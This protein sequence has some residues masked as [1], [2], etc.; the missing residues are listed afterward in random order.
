MISCVLKSSSGFKTVK[1]IQFISR[2]YPFLSHFFKQNRSISCCSIQTHKHARQFNRR[3][4]GGFAIPD[5]QYY[6]V[7]NS[8][9]GGRAMLFGLATIYLICLNKS[10]CSSDILLRL[11]YQSCV[12]YLYS[13]FNIS[14]DLM[15]EINIWAI[16]RIN[17]RP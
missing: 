17:H 10:R 12:C 7:S 16:D 3:V 11:T 14:Q 9:N 6:E 1:T 13:T 8:E 4:L 5:T 15:S 2:L